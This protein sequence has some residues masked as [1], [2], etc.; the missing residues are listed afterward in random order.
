MS[1]KT[2]AGSST[3][4]K[5]VKGCSIPLSETWKSSRCRPSTKFPSASV[6]TT[7][8]FTRSTLTRIA[9]AFSGGCSCASPGTG[10]HS[11]IR[12]SRAA[13]EK[14][15]SCILWLL[16]PLLKMD[17]LRILPRAARSVMQMARKDL[18]IRLGEPAGGFRWRCLFRKVRASGSRSLLRFLDP[19]VLH[20]LPVEFLKIEIAQ[21]I[22]LL[23]KL[24]PA[25]MKLRHSRKCGGRGN[26]RVA[27]EHFSKGIDAAGTE[28][29]L[30]RDR[31]MKEV[32]L[33]HARVALLSSEGDLQESR[34]SFISLRRELIAEKRANKFQGFGFLAN[35]EK[36]DLLGGVHRC[37]G[38]NR[39][40]FSAEHSQRLR[41]RH[42]ETRL[43]QS[44]N[45]IRVALLALRQDRAGGALQSVV[46][47]LEIELRG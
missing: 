31:Q 32:P 11:M 22:E 27:G 33:G 30:R 1:S 8:T 38:L 24:R 35:A 36:I 43:R 14:P 13:R 19:V 21:A 4:A 26:L 44:V 34:F 20:C 12:T 17:A 45:H 42:A 23:R 28:N 46:N 47:P 29:H 25:G 9:C 18:W 2:C 37:A 5:L 39:G 40:E 10:R 7:P 3:A 15:V 6:T 41:Q 16:E